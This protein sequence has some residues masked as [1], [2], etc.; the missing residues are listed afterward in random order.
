M[1]SEGSELSQKL[2]ECCV[3][4]SQEASR[5]FSSCLHTVCDECVEKVELADKYVC[6][7]CNQTSGKLITNGALCKLNSQNSTPNC[8]WCTEGGETN[9]SQGHCKECGQWLCDECI[10]GHNRMPPFRSHT[11]NIV[12]DCGDKGL[13]CE[14]HPR[15]SLELYCETCGV[16]TCRDCQLSVH[17]D[18]GG[19]R[20]VR[21]KAE[22]LRP[23][24]I[25]AINSL[26]AQV[27]QLRSFVDSSKCSPAD[28]LSSVAAA[29][30]AHRRSIDDLIRILKVSKTTFEADLDK[31]AHGHISKLHKASA[32]IQSLKER[33]TYTLQLARCLVDNESKDPASLVQ[34][35]GFIEERLSGLADQ[36]TFVAADGSTTVE[37]EKTNELAD[38]V[39]WRKSASS[40]VLFLPNRSPEELVQFLS[41]VFW[42]ANERSIDNNYSCNHDSYNMED[43]GDGHNNDVDGME[44][45]TLEESDAVALLKGGCAV[46]HSSGLLLICSVCCRTFHPQCHLPRLEMSS[47]SGKQHWTCSLCSFADTNSVNSEAICRI[48]DM[49]NGI[50]EPSEEEAP[51]ITVWTHE[52]FESGCRILLS[53]LCHPAAFCFTSSNAC[54][55]CSSDLSS[56]EAGAADGSLEDLCE[57]FHGLFRFRRCLEVSETRGGRPI[58]QWIRDIDAFT[59]YTCTKSNDFGVPTVAAT[60]QKAARSL[61][62]TLD[63]CVASHYPAFFEV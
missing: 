8:A 24:L 32:V 36:V 18:H 13:K 3:C 11:I 50:K 9:I 60:F 42:T 14:V 56:I 49:C 44:I 26:E 37:D 12:G 2:F 63:S 35:A 29:K 55:I 61:R 34:L 58:E 27:D 22:L 19:H 41:T 21:E 20:W 57:V 52:Q 46:C 1:K 6:A 62:E 51:G 43:T 28:I 47:V 23:G 39:G 17:R 7:R 40:R 38:A 4:G 53:L 59:V 5:L 33:I 16:L 15:E 30:V 45:E 31:A 10:K 25:S 54:P 48:R